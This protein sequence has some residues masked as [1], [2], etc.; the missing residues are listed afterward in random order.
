MIGDNQAVIP[1]TCFILE[2][3][4]GRVLGAKLQLGGEI[5]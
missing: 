1:H 5:L 3:R 4:G 2:G